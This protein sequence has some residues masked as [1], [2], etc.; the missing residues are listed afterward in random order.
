VL[1]PSQQVFL[2]IEGQRPIRVHGELFSAETS[3]SYQGGG[4]KSVKTK[5]SGVIIVSRIFSV[6]EV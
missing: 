5:Y 4:I 6:T 2:A 1:F 3:L